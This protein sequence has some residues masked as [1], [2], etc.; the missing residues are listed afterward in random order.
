MT[1]PSTTVSSR[2]VLRSVLLFT[3]A[4]TVL[5]A[6]AALVLSKFVWTDVTDARAIHASAWLA[7]GVQVITFIIAKIV[8]REQIIAAWALGFVLRLA[9]VGF[10]AFLGIKALALVPGPAL[11]SLV[12]FFF[13]STLIEPIFLNT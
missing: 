5:I 7:V 4:Q 3:L 2:G 1:T 10:W 8:S 12:M 9:V 11:W 13:V 6:L